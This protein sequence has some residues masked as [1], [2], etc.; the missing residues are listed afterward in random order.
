[1]R[2][3]SPPGLEPTEFIWIPS[4]P[5]QRRLPPTPIDTGARP[6]PLPPRGLSPRTPES[7]RTPVHVQPRVNEAGNTLQLTRD[8]RKTVLDLIDLGL[9]PHTVERATGT[10]RWQIRY[11]IRKGHPT[12]SKRPGRPPSLG[13]DIMAEVMAY[14]TASR[15]GRRATMAEL[16]DRLQLGVCARTIQLALQRE[17]FFRRV[18]HKKPPLNALHRRDR[19]AFA[20]W[21]LDLTLEQ[22]D[23]ILWTDETWVTGGHH[24]KIRVT[25]R[26]GEQWDDTCLVDRIQRRKG[27]MFWGGFLG[28]RKL[29]G[30]VWQKQWGKISALKYIQ[31]VLEAFHTWLSSEPDSA[32]LRQTLIFQQDNAP[33]HTA[34]IT[35]AW[36]QERGILLMKWPANSP[37]LSPIETIWCQM[38]DVLSKR[39]PEG[40]TARAQ[41]LV[42]QAVLETWNAVTTHALRA[43]LETMP[44]RCHE[45][46]A[47]NGGHIGW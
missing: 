8:E 47:A 1:M 13:R 4:P 30:I 22:R 29:P 34:R 43:Q 42:E 24:R 16:A 38:K 31:R 45:V 3:R 46:I 5:P 21:Y 15:E 27:W 19:L 17:G 14:I 40:N 26:V 28:T 11:A 37:D 6:G 35:R 7:P 9:S 18:A 41:R 36:F 39:C 32:Q 25:R 44:R 2:P 20:R 23:M 10:T 33:S 12:P